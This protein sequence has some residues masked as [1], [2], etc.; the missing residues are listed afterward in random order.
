MLKR[1]GEYASCTQR[2]EEIESIAKRSGQ[3]V[4][5]NAFHAAS[6]SSFTL[7][8]LPLD[9]PL[10]LRLPALLCRLTSREDFFSGPW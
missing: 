3:Y 1:S 8:L 4:P 2:T 7:L 6:T 5:P 10:T 9:V